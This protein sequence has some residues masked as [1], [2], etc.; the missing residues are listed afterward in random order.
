MIINY[1]S[2]P[3]YMRQGASDYVEKGIR[4]GS[5]L[6]CVICNDLFGAVR[7]ADYINKAWLKDW[8][9]FFYNETPTECWGSRQ[10]ME[11]WIRTKTEER[12]EPAYSTWGNEDE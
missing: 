7:R 2:L 4:P 3:E 11:N 9:L 12:N 1:E 6:T 5:F 8:C 10:K